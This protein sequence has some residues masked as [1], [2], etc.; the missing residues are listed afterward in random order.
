MKP[1]TEKEALVRLSTQCVKSE[2]CR[3]EM[4]QKLRRMNLTDEQRQHVLNQLVEEKFVDDKRFARAFVS[5]K[6]KYNGWGRRK[7]EQALRMKGVA[8]ADYREALDGVP[9]DD[10]EETLRELI[11]RKWATIHA[12]SDYE[13]SG[14]LIRFAMGRG[15][16]LEEIRRCIDGLSNLDDIGDE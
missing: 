14:K 10:Y 15:F 3:G 8:E 6:V 13:R 2:H 9:A 7:I 12:S 5:D 1:M 4:M 16:S 11:K